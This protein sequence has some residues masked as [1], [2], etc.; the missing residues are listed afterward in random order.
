[1]GLNNPEDRE[2][3][4]CYILNVPINAKQLVADCNLDYIQKNI[5]EVVEK[6]SN[7]TINSFRGSG[8]P[9]QL[10][11]ALAFRKTSRIVLWIDFDQPLIPT[12]LRNSLEYLQTH[13]GNKLESNTLS[14]LKD[15][16]ANS[17]ITEAAYLGFL[18]Y[19]ILDECKKLTVVFESFGNLF[20]PPFEHHRTLALSIARLSL[21]DLAVIF[22]SGHEYNQ[23]EQELL[24]DLWGYY[25]AHIIWGK[26]FAFD[27]KSADIQLKDKGFDS[28]FVY[29]LANFVDGDPTLYKYCEVKALR[30]EEFQEMFVATNSIP[31]QYELIGSDWLDWR[32]KEIVTD[33]QIESVKVLSAGKVSTSEFCL[34]AGLI[35]N[36]TRGITYFHPLFE[37]YLKNRLKLDQLMEANKTPKDYLTGQELKV[38]SLLLK[39]KNK[40][41][42]RD[43]VAKIMWLDEWNDKYSDWSIDKVISNIKKKLT[44]HQETLNVKTYKKEGFMISG[45]SKNY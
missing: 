16:I 12:L 32:Y 15:L 20:K 35:A 23:H 31:K 11:Q 18:K 4:I 13:Y 2:L 7:I 30:E 40:I 28:R 6:N 21:S 39:N 26:D 1:L 3:A 44:Q 36:G 19:L 24:G 41:V 45:S 42:T 37:Y 29:K 33:L 10:K 14:I 22:L 25:S 17:D 5:L 38:Y 34:E 8:V 9:F 43:E 27:R